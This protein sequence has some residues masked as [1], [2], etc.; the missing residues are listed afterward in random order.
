MEEEINRLQVEKLKI[1]SRIASLQ[2]QLDQNESQ[3]QL[4]EMN[5]YGRKSKSSSP[6]GVH[7][8]SREMIHRYSRHLL[9]PDF[10]IRG[11]AN[12]SNSSILVVG[13]G[14]LGS[15]IALYLAACGVGCLGIIDNDIVELNNLQRQ[16][17]HTEAFIGKPKVESA[18]AACR[19]INSTIDVVEHK[20]A[21]LAVN[22]LDIMSKYDVVV[23]ATD[24]IPTRYMINDGCVLLNKVQFKD[25]S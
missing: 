11:Q 8:L 7:G 13:A 15:P 18:A 10:G 3:K 6:Y 1:E 19:A 24:N 17:I 14:G 23:D 22:A 4:N 12:L 25:I 5:L 20:E 2:S 21:L 9:L 16:I